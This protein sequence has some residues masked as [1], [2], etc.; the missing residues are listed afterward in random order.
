MR[1]S[2]TIEHVY[3]NQKGIPAENNVSNHFEKD[4]F[5][6]NFN[7][8]RSIFFECGNSTNVVCIKAKVPVEYFSPDVK[9]SI[10]INFDVDMANVLQVTNGKKTVLVI[11]PSIQLD[12]NQFDNLQ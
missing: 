5:L 8:S 4:R 11:L 12:F 7:A 2:D 9:M 10:I 3:N 1:D 6:K